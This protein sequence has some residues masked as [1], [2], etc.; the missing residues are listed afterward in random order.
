MYKYFKTYIPYISSVFHSTYSKSYNLIYDQVYGTIK[1]PQKWIEDIKHI[2]F[3]ELLASSIGPLALYFGWKK[4]HKEEFSEIAS[5]ALASSFIHGDPIGTITSIV[6]LAYRYSRSTNKNEFRNLK[7]GIVKGGLT[8]SAFALTVKAMGFSLLGFLVGICIATIVRKS[9][10]SLRF[11]EY[12]KYLKSLKLR[13]PNV[14]KNIS[15]REFLTL[16][17]LE[18]KNV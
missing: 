6:V 2:H 8:V 14:K 17:F 12:I 5:G 9:V 10:S 3:D 18:F 1:V 11:F 4:R 16:N 13:V 7:W 15:R